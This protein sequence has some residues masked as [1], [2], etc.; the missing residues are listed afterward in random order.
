MAQGMCFAAGLIALINGIP[1]AEM[2]LSVAR[3]NVVPLF[4]AF[5]AFKMALDPNNIS[6]RR[7]DYDTGVVKKISLF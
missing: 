7:W 1:Q 3:P 2:A 5:T 4:N 6:N